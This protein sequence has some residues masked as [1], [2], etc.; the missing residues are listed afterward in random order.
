[1]NTVNTTT[2]D[3]RPQALGWMKNLLI[4]LG[5]SL[6]LTLAAKVMVPFWPVNI[7][8][9]S[10]AL[11][12][13]GFTLGRNLA[14]ASVALYLLEGALGMPVFTGV[15]SGPAYFAGTTGGYLIGFAATA[16]L[17]GWFM[18]KGCG[19][20][21]VASVAASTV[22]LACTYVLGVT[23]LANLIGL[24]KAI[25]GGLMIFIPSALCQ[26]LLASAYVR[27]RHKA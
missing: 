14:L 6:L 26:I 10:T 22:A 17:A 8:L 24:E 5:G 27:L 18:E 7:T 21:L 4:A 19:A 3:T 13:L 9:Q 15:G 11:L 20:S 23:W 2:F 1:M 16:Y 12:V 25:Q